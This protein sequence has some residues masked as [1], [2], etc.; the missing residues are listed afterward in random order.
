VTSDAHHRSHFTSRPNM[1]DPHESVTAEYD[2]LAARLTLLAL[3]ALLVVPASHTNGR[4]AL[5]GST[6]IMGA[7]AMA[8]RLAAC[9]KP[10]ECTGELVGA[11]LHVNCR[12]GTERRLDRGAGL[13]AAR[14][15]IGEWT[16]TWLGR[17][18]KTPP[19]TLIEARGAG[20][21]L[22]VSIDVLWKWQDEYLLPDLALSTVA[23]DRSARR[24][25]ARRIV[26]LTPTGPVHFSVVRTGAS[27]SGRN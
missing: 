16:K 21:G 2:I 18:R 26:R 7:D 6:E 17:P 15:R 25:G 22:T 24:N 1:G 12:Q 4:Y 20:E 27:P 9:E 11:V 10:V 19:E 5:N 8:V 13:G 23:A 3:R 14:H